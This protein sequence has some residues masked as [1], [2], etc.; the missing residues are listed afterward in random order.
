VAHLR[1][2]T[3][4]ALGWGVSAEEGLGGPGCVAG[5]AS[6]GAAGDRRGA[7][8][9]GGSG[10]GGG[11]SASEV[12]A[13]EMFPR[14]ASVRD[15]VAAAAAAVTDVAQ[16]TTTAVLQRPNAVSPMAVVPPP[17]VICSRLAPALENVRQLTL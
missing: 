16:Y 15:N 9:T 7:G 6:N 3:A 17:P 4:G 2:L 11:G 8:G 5:G 13:R 10:W 12:P 14:G 1:G